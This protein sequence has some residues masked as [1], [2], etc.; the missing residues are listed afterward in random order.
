MVKQTHCLSHP[1]HRRGKSLLEHSET[2]F[3]F[4]CQIKDE[5]FLY[6]SSFVYSIL[7]QC[8]KRHHHRHVHEFLTSHK[9]FSPRVM[10][11][12][13]TSLYIYTHRYRLWTIVIDYAQV[14]GGVCMWDSAPCVA[15]RASRRAR[16]CDKRS[17][18]DKHL[19]SVSSF[20]TD[21]VCLC[22]LLLAR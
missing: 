2:L 21:S 7:D 13:G 8:C 10:I 18:K 17:D 4:I 19:C 1:S 6:I 5:Q 16:A 20:N 12:T 3:N 15:R 22:N 9:W 11:G 14:M